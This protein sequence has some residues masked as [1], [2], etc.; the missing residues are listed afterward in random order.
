MEKFKLTQH[1]YGNR[2]GRKKASAIQTEPHTV[3]SK[4]KNAEMV[5]YV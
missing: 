4:K 1:A 3:F 2:E 5:A